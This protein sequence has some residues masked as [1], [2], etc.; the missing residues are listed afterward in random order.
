[1]LKDDAR[2]EDRFN[3]LAT[4]VQAVIDGITKLP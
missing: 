3:V 1:M 2:S 4:L